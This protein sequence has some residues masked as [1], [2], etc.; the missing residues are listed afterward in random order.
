M[1]TLSTCPWCRKTKQ[2]FKDKNVPFDYVD[3]D[4]A[5]EEEQERI[6]KEMSKHGGST[7]FPFVK[8]GEEVIIGYN[9]EKYGELLGL[10]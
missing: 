8:I 10:R 1:Y 4:R 6:R 5:S 9:P 7:A 3:Y 2:F